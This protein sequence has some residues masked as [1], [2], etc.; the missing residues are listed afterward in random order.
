M[1]AL[2]FTLLLLGSACGTT[3]EPGVPPAASTRVAIGP[4]S[5]GIDA[6]TIVGKPAPAW[7]LDWMGQPAV[8]LDGLRGQVV[9][10]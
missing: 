10:V 6:T 1:R 8:S 7:E 5:A 4:D 2:S 9:L 3:G